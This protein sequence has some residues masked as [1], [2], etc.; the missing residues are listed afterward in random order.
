MDKRPSHWTQNEFYKVQV[1]KAGFVLM[2][3][4]RPGMFTMHE[5]LS[6]WIERHTKESA[7]N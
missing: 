1:N 6:E 5:L 3:T 7:C 4:Y 2:V